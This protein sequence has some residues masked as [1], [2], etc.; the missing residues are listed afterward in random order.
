[1]QVAVVWQLF[2]QRKAWLSA[3]QWRVALGILCALHS[4]LCSGQS[5]LDPSA[6][7]VQ[8][9][10]AKDTHQLSSGLAWDWTPKWPLLGGEVTGYWELSVSGW[11][12]PSMDGRQQAWLGQ[13]GVVPTFRYMPLFGRSDWF[14]EI[15]VGAAATTRLYQTNQ[16]RFSTRF[17]F[18]DHIA[19]G[20]RFGAAREHELALRLRHFSN[21]GIKQPNPGENFVEVRYV[22]RF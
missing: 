21:A 6:C 15:G 20:L 7:F 10:T 22:H 11:S 4:T 8:L 19:V 13:L 14:A 12:Y 1:M 16:K 3:W 9:G 17:N 2:R 18:A 5:V